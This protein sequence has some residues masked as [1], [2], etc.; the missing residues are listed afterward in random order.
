MTIKAEK[1]Y[2]SW[3]M[4]EHIITAEF[5]GIIFIDDVHLEMNGLCK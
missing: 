2:D 4:I 1:K 3:K 5:Q